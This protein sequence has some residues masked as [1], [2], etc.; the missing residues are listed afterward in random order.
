MKS[1]Q[2]LLQNELF[3][4]VHNRYIVNLNEVESYRGNALGL[5][6]KM[7]N[8]SNKLPV[9]RGRVNQFKEAFSQVENTRVFMVRNDPGYRFYSAM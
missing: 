6:L 2:K 1:A 9:S 4:R 5:S 7:K 8:S 3:I